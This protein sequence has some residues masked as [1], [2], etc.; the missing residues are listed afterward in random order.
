MALSTLSFLVVFC[1]LISTGT[2]TASAQSSGTK[3]P[4][5]RKDSR[6]GPKSTLESDTAQLQEARR[7]FAIQVVSSLAD[8]AR[9][10]KDE[11][12][13][14]RIQA[15]AADVLWNTDTE[16]ARAL[17]VRAWDAAQTVDKEG[18]RRNKEERQRFLSKRGG[19][20]FIPA[21][22]NLRAEV[23]RPA[24]LHEP[25]L[26]EGFLAKMEEENRRDEEDSAS[27]SRWDPTEPPDATIK[28]LQLA[29]QLLENGETQRAMLLAEPG[30][31]RV[32]SQ[33]VMFLVLLRQKN[34]GAA[35]QLFNSLL[36]RTS[37]DSLADAT[38]VSLLSTYVFTPSVFVTSTRNGLLM[39]PWTDPLPPPM[40]S[41]DLRAKFF[42][43][44]SQILLRPLEPGTLELT[45]AGIAGTYFTIKRL[46][47]LFEQNDPNIA[48]A[49]QTRLNTLGQGSDSLI[50]ASQRGFVNA[51]FK[52]DE[53]K[54]DDP[55]DAL[56]HLDDAST[57]QRNH[58]YAMAA[59]AASMK[60]DPKA[61]EFADKIEDSD[62]K[63]SVRNFVDFIL[64][65]KALALRDL[66]KALH[67]TRTGEISHFQ[68]AWA[69][70]EIAALSNS[71]APEDSMN[72]IREAEREAERI[73]TSAE[74][75][76]AWVAIARRA[77]EIDPTGKWYRV[78]DAIK[79]VNRV[80]D[81]TGEEIEISVGFQSQNNIIKMQI[82]APTIS[83][84]ALI[85][86]LAKDDI[87]RTVAMAKNV[88]GE[89]PR[90]F[91]LLASARA[92]FDKGN[93][94]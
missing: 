21:P 94:R 50:P 33:G 3:P 65:S 18:K 87:Y 91:S 76:E 28:R 79:A 13:S 93:K 20:G 88:T 57:S 19:T 84:S 82:P 29:R 69:Y 77:G 43:V 62:L 36:E 47:P 63:K 45:S 55:G 56:S 37:S 51:G 74:G 22:P 8:E 39:N 46:L 24:Y 4:P 72:L 2:S 90:A 40:L 60:N 34:A 14:V 41:P 23:L 67:L 92:A 61:R 75:A 49:L 86:D 83:F 6:V 68:R 66:E 11:S 7:T 5:Q 32:T 81:Y 30:L 85:A 27:S 38:S 44:T 26:A 73:E 54:E 89:S 70:S 71:S 58:L 80:L 31:N 1:C 42:S 48:I 35:D 59:R 78:Q 9:S 64:V 10:Y 52:S 15:R 12:L 53:K 16:R 17:F 25:A